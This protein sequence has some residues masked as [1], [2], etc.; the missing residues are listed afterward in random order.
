MS[1]PSYVP[2]FL[3]DLLNRFYE[4]DFFSPDEIWFFLFFF[5]FFFFLRRFFE[6]F[7]FPKNYPSDSHKSGTNGFSSVSPTCLHEI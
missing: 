7:A 1:L 4:N 5:L 2:Q 6:K 3:F